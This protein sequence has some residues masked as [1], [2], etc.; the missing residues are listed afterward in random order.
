MS[1]DAETVDQM[2]HSRSLS[3]VTSVVD[4]RTDVV[5]EAGE[6]GDDSDFKIDSPASPPFL[7]RSG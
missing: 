3:S 5:E 2:K 4:V 1:S 6:P 7:K